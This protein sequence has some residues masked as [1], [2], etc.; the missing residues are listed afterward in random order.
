MTVDE[1]TEIFD[2]KYS[3]KPCIKKI[4]DESHELAQKHGYVAPMN[5]Y[6]STIHSIKSVDK[7]INNEGSRQSFNPI[8]D[9]T[10]GL[11]TTL[12]ITYIAELIQNKFMKSK[13]K[14]TLHNT[15][16][17][18]LQPEDVN[19]LVNHIV[20]VMAYLPCE[21]FLK[22]KING[23][24]RQYPIDADIEIG[25][26]YNDMVEYNQEALKNCSAAT[27]RISYTHYFRHIRDYHDPGTPTEALYS[28][29]EDDQQFHDASSKVLYDTV[30]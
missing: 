3:T 11:L 10:S 1:A 7:D 30:K 25:L 4:I 26:T 14:T 22:I 21:D 16:V 15:T 2:K 17:V 13:L 23:E 29:K 12:A 19:L 28:D 8:T 9:S 24:L 5:V 20:N 18:F 27:G 6:R